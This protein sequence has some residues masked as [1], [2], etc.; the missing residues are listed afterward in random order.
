MT[1]RVARLAALA[2]LLTA[3][4]AGAATIQGTVFED[5]NYGGGAGRSLAASGGTVVP[6][7]RIELYNP[8]GTFRTSTNTNAAGAYSFA[9][10]PAGTYTVR[11]ANRSIASTRTGGCAAGTC[12]PV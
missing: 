2:I 12:L 10:L 9:G 3:H 11:A 8:S 6:N 4:A 1:R 7:V 5:R